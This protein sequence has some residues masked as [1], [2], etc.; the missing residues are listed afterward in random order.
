LAYEIEIEKILNLPTEQHN[1]YQWVHYW[2]A[3]KKQ[4]SKQANK[5][6]ST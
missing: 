1:E 4:T 6:T 5:Y 2:R 3:I